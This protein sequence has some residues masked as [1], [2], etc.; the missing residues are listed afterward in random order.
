MFKIVSNNKDTTHSFIIDTIANRL[1]IISA[2]HQPFCM[3]AIFVVLLYS[4]VSF[5]AVLISFSFFLN[6]Y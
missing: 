2:D 6:L 1:E 4:S 3:S 5:R